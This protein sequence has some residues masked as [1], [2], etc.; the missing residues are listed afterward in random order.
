MNQYEDKFHLRNL[1]FLKDDFQ[2]TRKKEQDS[3]SISLRKKKKKDFINFQRFKSEGKIISNQTTQDPNLTDI[4]SSIR[5]IQDNYI[6]LDAIRNLEKLISSSNDHDFSSEINKEDIDILVKLFHENFLGSSSLLLSIFTNLFS[7]SPQLINIFLE[8]DGLNLLTSFITE[9]KFSS[10]HS[11]AL[12]AISNILYEKPEISIYLLKPD[13]IN[14]LNENL[15][16]NFLDLIIS[17]ETVLCHIYNNKTPLNSQI[18][19]KFLTTIEK[20]LQ[21]SRN[22][23][24]LFWILYYIT[25]NNTDIF[26][27]FDPC[28]LFP[29]IIDNTESIY[30]EILNPCR[31]IIE[32][33]SK[34][35]YFLSGKLIK[36]GLLDKIDNLMDSSKLNFL[37]FAVKTFADFMKFHEFIENNN[38]NKDLFLRFF[39][40]IDHPDISVKK[41]IIRGLHEILKSK[42]YK[43]IS[44]FINQDFI[45]RLIRSL[46]L[47]IMELNFM[48][49]EIIYELF[50]VINDLCSYELIDRYNNEFRNKGGIEIL[51]QITADKSQ[52]IADMAKKIIESFFECTENYY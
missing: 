49:L 30:A 7:N 22:Y 25:Q 1:K 28:I 36:F 45:E 17:T 5:G 6:M 9:A 39:Y 10:I 26:L 41:E 13:L 19:M 32:E 47:K 3:F 14:I 44:Q 37:V 23:S 12:K 35:S 18:T 40:L 50:D 34:K 43:I 33:I 20:I 11:E 15:Q 24:N 4:L 8:K 38:D 31:K 2:I 16:S 51:E 48:I 27:V 42:D 46:E 29:F 21:N 52:M